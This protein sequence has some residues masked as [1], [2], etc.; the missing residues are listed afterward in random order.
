MNRFQP[1]RPFP[2]VS[3]WTVTVTDSD[4]L[5]NCIFWGH[6]HK[7]LSYSGSYW[8][9]TEMF[10]L[11]SQGQHVHETCQLPLLLGEICLRLS[12]AAMYFRRSGRRAH[13]LHMPLLTTADIPADLMT[14]SP[15][16]LDLPKPS[17]VSVSSS[18]SSANSKDIHLVATASINGG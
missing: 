18:S 4:R 17:D 11:S 13:W 8:D 6:N 7:L 3:V 1:A 10:L 2:G 12:T 9:L 5:L 14:T 15:V 16:R